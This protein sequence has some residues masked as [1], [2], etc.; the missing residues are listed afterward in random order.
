M[1][2]RLRGQH[3]PT[4][5]HSRLIAN[6]GSALTFAFQLTAVDQGQTV[7]HVNQVSSSRDTM[8]LMIIDILLNQPPLL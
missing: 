2:H 6:A 7:L 1:Q 3:S 5:S 4:F 8:D